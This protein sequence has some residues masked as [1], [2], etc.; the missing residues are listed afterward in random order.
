MR[1]E[2]KRRNV[3]YVQLIEALAA[4]RQLGVVDSGPNIRNK[5]ARG[6]LQRCFDPMPRGYLCVIV[7]LVGWL[8]LAASNPPNE[9]RPQ[10]QPNG[11]SAPASEP[12]PSPTAK[13]YAPYPGVNDPRCYQASNH[14]SADLCAQWRAAF[15]TEKAANATTSANLISGAGAALSFISIVLVCIAL[16]QTRKANKLSEDTARRQL[17]AYIALQSATGGESGT[18]LT[19]RAAMTNSGQTPAHRVKISQIFA[20]DREVIPGPFRDTEKGG[21]LGP[22]GTFFV[23]DEIDLTPI[24]EQYIREELDIILSIHIEYF[25]IYDIR[26]ETKVRVRW[27]GKKSFLACDT[28]NIAT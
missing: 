25:D 6:K 13:P 23:D 27:A 4:K 26:R 22:G 16:G 19:V 3:I 21:V 7:V 20:M 10:V 18:S 11:H 1:S 17:R 8:I 12:G 5:L 24:A 14:D 15:A 2:L 28:G 9:R